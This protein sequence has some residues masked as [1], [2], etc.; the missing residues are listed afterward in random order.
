MMAENQQ[1]GLAAKEIINPRGAVIIGLV[2]MI[3]PLG[4]R[5]KAA[6]RA[7][8]FAGSAARN[9]RQL[10]MQGRAAASARCHRRRLRRLVQGCRLGRNLL[11]Q[12]EPGVRGGRTPG[13]DEV[14]VNFDFFRYFKSSG[15]GTSG[16]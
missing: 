3:S 4:N 1:T 2:M 8:Y 13:T 5:A 9:L 11:Q 10:D 12:V 16:I 7:L 15:G 6:N 14:M